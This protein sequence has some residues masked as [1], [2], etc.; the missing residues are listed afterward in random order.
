MTHEHPRRT[1]RHER[2]ESHERPD[3]QEQYDRHGRHHRTARRGDKSTIIGWVIVGALLAVA[4]P[5]ASPYLPEHAGRAAI[6]AVFAAGAVL[7]LI[8]G[9]GR[10]AA[11]QPGMGSGLILGAVAFGVLFKVIGLES[12]MALIRSGDK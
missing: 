3:R 4:I 7:L 12:L 10:F 5:V 2:H 1:R 11:R 9:L 6:G 8:A